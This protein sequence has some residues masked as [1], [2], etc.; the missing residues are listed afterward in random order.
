[1]LLGQITPKPEEDKKRDQGEQM[2]VEATEHRIDEIKRTEDKKETK[3]QGRETKKG[4]DSV[5]KGIPTLEKK[6]DESRIKDQEW[7]KEMI[8]KL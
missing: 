1:M 4:D 7:K 5:F 3:I 2:D 8:Q 6:M